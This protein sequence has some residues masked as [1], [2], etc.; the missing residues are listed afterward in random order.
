MLP[1]AVET[2]INLLLRRVFLSEVD[3]VGVKTIQLKRN[4]RGTSPGLGLLPRRPRAAHDRW[5]ILNMQLFNSAGGWNQLLSRQQ[6]QQ[7]HR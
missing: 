2:E 6:I 4:K 3:L 5:L 7:F 1:R